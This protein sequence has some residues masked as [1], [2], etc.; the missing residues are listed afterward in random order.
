M[1]RQALLQTR[2][3]NTITLGQYEPGTVQA[4]AALR[5]TLLEGLE[6]RRKDRETC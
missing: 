4:P 6:T 3:S 1:P 5:M 2:F